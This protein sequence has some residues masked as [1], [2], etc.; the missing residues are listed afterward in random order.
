MFKIN[1][2]PEIQQEKQAQ[3][4]K[5]NYAIIGSLSIVSVTIAI[6]IIIGS[7]TA[8]QN[9]RLNNTKEDIE[10]INKESEQYKDL[11]KTVLSL[12]EGLGGVK[13]IIEGKNSWTKLFPHLETATPH[14]ITFKSL[15]ISPEGQI[16]A[17]LEGINVGS[18]ARFIES[19]KRYQVISL[20]GSGNP[21]D[22]V[23]INHNGKE[24]QKTIMPSGSWKHA[25]HI[26]PNNPQELIITT[27]EDVYRLSYSPDNKQITSDRNGILFAVKNLFTNVTTKGY[28]VNENGLIGFESTFDIQGGL[29]W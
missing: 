26:N 4:K 14:D 10:K 19:Y 22:I 3:A 23:S 24:T 11:E 17:S 12:E 6:I 29:L 16:T 9:I 7:L 5:N 8:V 1:L 20:S 18:L 13:S 15:G 27:G 28:S 25:T 21:G 2:A